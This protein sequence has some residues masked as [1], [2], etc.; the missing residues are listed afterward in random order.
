MCFTACRKF[1]VIPAPLY[2][3]YFAS[4]RS[5]M[6]HHSDGHEEYYKPVPPYDKIVAPGEAASFVIVSR[7][8][9]LLAFFLSGYQSVMSHGRLSCCWGT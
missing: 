5:H 1:R 2:L 8:K 3:Q 9:I 4:D 7:L 6:L